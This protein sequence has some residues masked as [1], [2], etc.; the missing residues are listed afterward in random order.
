MHAVVIGDI[1][2]F[3]RRRRVPVAFTA[4]AMLALLAAALLAPA[5]AVATSPQLTASPTA[6]TAG[7][8]ITARGSGFAK[9]QAGSLLFDTATVGTAFRANGKGTFSVTLPVPATVAT[10]DH[11]VS[12]K[13]SAN[14]TLA[15]TTITVVASSPSPAPTTTPTTAP[16]PT[17]TPTLASTS[18]SS[19]PAVATRIVPVRTA[20]ELAAALSHAAGGDAIE[21]A[22]GVYAGRFVITR[23]GTNTAPITLCGGRQAILDGGG[24]T[25]GY[26]VALQA[27]YWVLAGFTVRHSNKGIMT[28]HANFN[29]LRGLEVYG[30]GGEG[31]HLRRFSSHNTVQGNFIHDTGLYVA[32]DGEGVYVGSAYTN[33]CT[34]TACQPDR[35]DANQIIGNT[36]GPNTTAESVD[37][38][39]GT[40]GG[41]VSGNTFDG[42]G[43]TA[44]DSW[45][46]AKGNGYLI[47][48]NTGTN[49]PTD[50]FQTHI[51]L[52][53]WGND[54][55]FQANIANV[56]AAG[57]GFRIKV[58]SI[59][60][61]VTCD[62][63]VRYASQGYANVACH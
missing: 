15:S 13:S 39:E 17:P 11:A 50:G 42:S 61:L 3:S 33:W 8:S 60:D 34:Y 37:L 14:V 10:G 57:Y 4:S 7:S 51:Q 30:T 54:N 22:D 38:K 18:G 56:H 47:K 36:I 52:A 19:C 5:A 6:T 35:S 25:T 31:I 20:T 29:V 9:N 45:V 27:D 32:H 28:D 58:G 59:G 62:N 55:I 63:I 12:A 46:D 2:L 26:G 49:A 40:T 48:A 16:T 24:V 23:S 43:M 53:G 44:A 41:L 1:P 21:L